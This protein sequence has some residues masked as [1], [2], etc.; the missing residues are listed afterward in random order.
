MVPDPP[1]ALKV[2]VTDP[3]GVMTFDGMEY[4]PLPTLVTAAT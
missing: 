2:R 4:A 3:V 1:F